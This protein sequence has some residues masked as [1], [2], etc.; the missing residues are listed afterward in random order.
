M[1]LSTGCAAR[2]FVL[3]LSASSLGCGADEGADEPSERERYL[4]ETTTNW[5]MV[6]GYPRGTAYNPHE[7]ELSLQTVAD[8]QVRWEVASDAASVIQH[9]ERAFASD[10]SA[11][12]LESGELLWANPLEASSVVCKGLVVSTGAR[13]DGRL[14]GTGAMTL[15]SSVDDGMVA[16]GPPTAK[17]GKVVFTGVAEGWESRDEPTSGRVF[18]YDV[19]ARAVEEME[20]PY[21]TLAPAALSNGQLYSTAIDSTTGALELVAFAVTID[22]E[23]AGRRREWATVIGGQASRALPSRGVAVLD[24]HVFV[25]S[26]DGREILSLEQ[27]SGAVAWRSPSVAAITSFAVNFD[28]VYT[29]GSDDSGELWVQS[30]AAGSGALRYSRALGQGEAKGQLA[31]GGDVLYLGTTSGELIALSAGTGN[32]LKRVE[33]GGELGSPL[34]ARGLVLLTTGTRIVALGLPEVP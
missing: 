23:T 3:F 5:A 9:G 16:F 33:L 17:D 14:A 27:R 26:G 15:Q 28:D 22:S 25:A 19:A 10:G 31:I 24:G 4:N 18:S 11:Y 21:L 20:L 13:I 12:Q 29:V 2:L 30:F 8:L 1:S 34:V 7:R 6:R 32:V